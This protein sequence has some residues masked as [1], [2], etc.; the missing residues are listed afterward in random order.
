MRIARH[1]N[2]AVAR[3]PVTAGPDR[4]GLE[5]Q[6]TGHDALRRNPGAVQNFIDVRVF[7][8]F[9]QL[10]QV[11]SDHCECSFNLSGVPIHRKISFCVDDLDY[12]HKTGFDNLKKHAERYFLSTKHFLG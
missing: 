11:G 3:T 5:G 10:R 7:V 1:R 6:R 4:F 12:A 9:G 8:F 2:A